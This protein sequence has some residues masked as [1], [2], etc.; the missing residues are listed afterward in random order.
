VPAPKARRAKKKP[1]RRGTPE[2]VPIEKIDPTRGK[3]EPRNERDADRD[4]QGRLR[5]EGW[6]RNNSDALPRR[7][8]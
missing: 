7:R 8:D 4:A 1:Q 5:T 6:T 2:P 3:V